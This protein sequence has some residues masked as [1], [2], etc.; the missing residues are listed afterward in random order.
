MDLQLHAIYRDP[1]Y[2][3]NYFGLGNETKKTSDDKNYN[4]VRIG[5]LHVNPEISKTI[6][7]STLTAGVFYQQ[8]EV[9]NTEGR[10]ISDIPNNGLNPEIFE[11]QRFAGINL[12]YELDSRNDRVLPTRGIY[13]NTR[14]TFN[15]CLSS[16]AHTYNQ[17]SSDF[18][19][20]LSFRKPYR[21]VIA[22][23][24]GGA[25]NVG[26]YE[27][28]QA[29]SVGGQNNLRGHRSTRYSGDANV[30]QNTELRFKL[31]NFATYIAKGEAGILG[32][33]DFGRVW[34]AGE[35]SKVWHHGA[36]GGFWISPFR[37]AVLNAMWEW[38]KDEPNGLFSF[39]FRFLF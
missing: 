26:D 5:Q 18:S 37:L 25:L 10:Y 17:L 20:F 6:Q 39:R 15:Y 35:D 22:F 19:F 23:R 30:Y 12:R 13:W 16:N 11:S 21:T 27:F 9:E 29:C 24:A 7:K 38:S 3:E 1:R 32:F 14:S 4:R 34:L 31:F 28:F 36:G 33:N 2:A 8:F